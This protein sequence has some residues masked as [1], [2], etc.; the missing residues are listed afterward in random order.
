MKFPARPKLLKA[1]SSNDFASSSQVIG[2]IDKINRQ[3]QINEESDEEKQQTSDRDES[4]LPTKKFDI[5]LTMSQ[6]LIQS[7]QSD[8]RY[9]TSFMPMTVDIDRIQS[10]TKED[11]PPLQLTGSAIYEDKQT[12]ELGFSIF[13]SS[14]KDSRKLCPQEAL[15]Q[16]FAVDYP[17]LVYKSVSPDNKELVLCHLAQDIPQ[18]Q[19][20]LNQWEF[21]SFVNGNFDVR[22]LDTRKQI[23]F[24]ARHRK[25]NKVKLVALFIDPW[26]DIQLSDKFDM[27]ENFFVAKSDI[28]RPQCKKGEPLFMHSDDKIKNVYLV[29]ST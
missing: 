11:G 6:S 10:L 19:I 5:E 3:A 27:Q 23:V 25:L 4:F 18:R 2:L 24:L 12:G 16:S 22:D 29:P 7:M 15:R 9:L 8:G 26:K 13:R 1:P 28:T 17:I 14:S 20:H 21:I